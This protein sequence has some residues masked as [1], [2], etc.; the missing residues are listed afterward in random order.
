MKR[1]TMQLIAG[2]L[3]MTAVAPVFADEEFGRW[4]LEQRH[5]IQNERIKQGWHEGDITWREGAGLIGDRVRIHRMRRDF[6]DNGY[7]S[8]EERRA[9]NRAYTDSSLKIYEYKHNPYYRDGGY[10]GDPYRHRYYDDHRYRY[11]RYPGRGYRW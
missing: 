3:A 1:L 2:A 9:L 5:G 6:L 7:L 4:F 10:Y 8:P 11:D